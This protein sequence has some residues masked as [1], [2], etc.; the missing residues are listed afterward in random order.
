M[1]YTL[2]RLRMLLPLKFKTNSEVRILNTNNRTDTR[3]SFCHTEEKRKSDERLAYHFVTKTAKVETSNHSHIKPGNL[4]R[5]PNK[6]LAGRGM[7]SKN[8]GEARTGHGIV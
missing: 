4:R 5:G 3:L 2:E 1:V 6:G 7:K 8:G